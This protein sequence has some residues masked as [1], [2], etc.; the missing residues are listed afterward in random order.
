MD[1]LFHL[2]PPLHECYDLKGS[3]VDRHAKLHATVRKDSDWPAGR[4][5]RLQ[6]GTKRELLRQAGRDA[7]FLCA[8]RVMD[9]S[10]LLGIHNVVERRIFSGAGWN[11]SSGLAEGSGSTPRP[12]A[13]GRPPPVAIPAGAPAAG[14]REAG[15][16]SS[17]STSPFDTTSEG[18]ALSLLAEQ[19]GP[20]AFTASTFEGPGLYQMGLI[21]V[22]QRW[23][24]AKR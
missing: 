13:H 15:R 12:P 21:D 4:K 20:A 9:Y 19:T 10:L 11:S 8:C 22:L 17:C 16:P 24:V 3:W 7:R 6:P 5:L 18:P 2:C 23:T 1:N 14:A